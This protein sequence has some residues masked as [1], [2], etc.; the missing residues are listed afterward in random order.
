[1]LLP[2]SGEFASLGESTRNGIELALGQESDLIAAIFKDTGGDSTRA[3]A[4][5]SE[6]ITTDAPNVILGPLLSEQ[7][8]AVSDVV[9]RDGLPLL[10]FSKKDS[11][12]TGDGVFRLGPTASSQVES[13]LESA[14]KFGLQRFAVVSP[15]DANG[16]EFARVFKSRAP[17]YGVQVVFEA[18]YPKESADALVNIAREVENARPQAVFLPDSLLHASRFFSLISAESLH[19]IRPVGPASWDNPTELNQSRS[20]LEGAIFVSPFFMQSKNPSVLRFIDAYKARFKQSPNFLAAQGFDAATI[21]AAALRQGSESGNSFSVALQGLGRYE[22]LTGTMQVENSGE[23]KRSYSVVEFRAGSI[24][25]LGEANSAVPVA[26]TQSAAPIPNAG[27]TQAS[28]EQKIN[29]AVSQ[30]G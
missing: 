10:T 25:E 19:E 24:R 29:G 18:S 22:G 28:P 5:A 23:I 12:Q 16:Q 15:A 14:A 9:R 1:V 3:S 7:A 21:V 17:A 2:L 13:L 20:V 30:P 11:F 27:A 26:D 4:S 8:N 6:M